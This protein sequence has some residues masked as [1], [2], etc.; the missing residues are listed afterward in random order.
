M[1]RFYLNNTLVN[2]PANWAD[3]TETLEYDQTLKGLLPKYDIGLTWT[4][5]AFAFLF[6]IKETLGFCQLVEL[7]VDY[8][9]S[10]GAGYATELLG[11]IFISDCKFSLN[12]CEVEC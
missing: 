3:F 1:F 11:Y 8:Q 6:N 10:A 12:R 5:G 2:E 7:K 9:C 4:G